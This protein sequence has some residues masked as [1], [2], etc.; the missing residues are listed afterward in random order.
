MKLNKPIRVGA[1]L[2]LFL[3]F[4]SLLLAGQDKLP[5]TAQNNEPGL[6]SPQR[7]SW[8]NEKS[9]LAHY[10]NQKDS[11]IYYSGLA[12][13]EAKK[14]NDFH[15]MAISYSRLAQI[16]NQFDSDFTLM[17]K[18]G[19]E[20]LGYFDK[21]PDRTGIDTVYEIL[22]SAS[23]ALGHFEEA[24][25]YSNK[26]YATAIQ[27]KNI[28]GIFN[29]LTGMLA[30]NRQWGD[31]EK[32]FDYARQLNDIAEQTGN[33]KWVAGA[34]WNMAGLYKLIGD[35]SDALLY[36]QRA[37]N[38][39]EKEQIPER[40][41]SDQEE[42]F[43]IEFA[44]LFSQMQ[45][46]DSAW[47]YYR[48]FKS[49]NAASKDIYL[50]STGEYYFLQGNYHQA[51]QNYEQ[52]LEGHLK[53]NDINESMRTL[54]D[55]SG[56]WLALDNLPAALKYGREGLGL[57]LKTGVK[58][59][60]RDGY[61]LLADTYDRWQ[62]AD[63]SNYYFRKFIV[64]KEVVL[65]DQ[66]KGKFAAYQ[67]KQRISVMQQEEKVREMQLQRETWIKNILVGGILVLVLFAIVLFRN[68]ILKRRYDAR[69]RELAENELQIQ[70]LETA[71]AG[72]ELMQQ[73]S[74][75]EMKA[76]RA[77]MNPHFIFNCLNSINR[78]IIRNDAG[79]AAG[80][81]T[82]FAKLIRMVLENSGQAFIPLEEELNSLKLYLDLEAIRFENPFSYEIHGEDIDQAMVMIPSLLIQPFVENAIWHGLH[83]RT[84]KG[85]FIRID[86]N[87]E[88]NILHCA[89]TDNGV[90][91]SVSQYN[92]LNGGGS[93]KSMGIDLT[94]RRL[95]LA[96]TLQQE[97]VDVSILDLKDEAGNNAGTSVQI[98]ITVK[99]F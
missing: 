22:F 87:L 59:Y 6:Q 65:N 14:I 99:T 27:K 82:K 85:G 48:L 43:E 31:Y 33:K 84:A 86:L 20:A 37:R 91:R 77:Q 50:V 23:Y 4:N 10:R 46:F 79:K 93:G 9:A 62:Q 5:G 97:N 71:K 19:E 90:G 36:Y 28:N 54:L 47:H 1:G 2:F 88:N 98:H 52:G 16:A 3:I 12:M 57:A 95:Q 11:A 29:S 67:F 76:L 72:A 74:E 8:L 40:I 83:P 25:E 56:V 44:E 89:I 70:K 92:K 35:Y 24:M 30:I 60:I 78:F 17:Q 73:R 21:T 53:R 55:M 49:V 45:Q 66:A 94:R 38:I 32:C 13:A 64:V 41:H 58:Q 96:N 42:G 61:K 81:L 80:Y 39:H 69:R 51:L 68:I 63:S 34:L 18:Y 26:Y 7:V 15:G 75:L